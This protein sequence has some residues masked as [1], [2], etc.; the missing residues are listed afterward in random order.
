LQSLFTIQP[1]EL[2]LVH[3]DALTLQHDMNAPIAEAS[4]FRRNRLHG[5]TQITVIRSNAFVADT[6]SVENQNLALPTL[7][8]T[9]LIARVSYSTPLG[10]ER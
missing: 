7:A 8:D 6:R 2:L 3:Y 10:I 1:A 9:V 5:L 4:A